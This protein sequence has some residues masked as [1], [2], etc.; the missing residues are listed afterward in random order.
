[1]LSLTIDACERLPTN[2]SAL[3]RLGNWT[4]LASPEVVGEGSVQAFA[5]KALHGA[6]WPTRASDPLGE[7]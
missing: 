3:Q 6:H 5:A 7:L 1:M 4:H 2:P